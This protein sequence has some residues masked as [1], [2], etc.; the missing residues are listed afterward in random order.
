MF[1]IVAPGQGAQT[2]GM[3][4]G[5]LRDPAHAERLRHW[6]GAADLDLVHL[7]TRASAAAIARTENAQPLLVAHGLLAHEALA[8]AV[9]EGAAVVAGHS[10]GELTAA[11]Y[12]GVLT[13][14]DAIRL[15][16]VRGRA[17]GAACD[18]EPTSMAAVVGGSELDV[19]DRLAELD[20]TAATF[21]GTGQIVAAGPADGIQRLAAAPPRG[22]TVKPLPVAGAFH[23]PF[24]EPARQAVAAAAAATRFDRPRQLLL[25]NA[26]GAVLTSPEEIRQRLVDQVVRPVRWDLCLRALARMQ[27]GLALSLPP[28]RTLANILKRQYPG[29]AVVPVNVPRDLAKAA[30]RLEADTGKGEPAHAGA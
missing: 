23:T 9:P 7:G 6:S 15:A 5:W 1:A 26:D 10:V 22:A 20:L 2:P 11:V 14:T 18:A 28:A 21:N 3:L 27:P 30:A 24:M 13:S 16:A 29:I 17:M 4:S 19:L 12:A 8:R 25:S